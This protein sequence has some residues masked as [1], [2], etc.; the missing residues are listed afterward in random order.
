MKS[1]FHAFA[2]QAQTVSEQ[3]VAVDKCID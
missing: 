3:A 1:A 2:P